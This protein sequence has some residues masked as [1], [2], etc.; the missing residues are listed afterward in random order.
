MA[1]EELLAFGRPSLLPLIGQT[2]IEQ[3]EVIIPQVVATLKT[4]VEDHNLQ[5]RLLA[6]LLAL[7]DDE[8]IVTMIEKLSDSDELFSDT[9]FLRRVRDRA[10]QEGLAEGR[11]QARA[12]A[13]RLA[14]RNTILEILALRFD[15]PAL[16]YRK[17]EKTLSGV[18]TDDALE[19]LFVIAIQA[20]TLAEFETALQQE[21]SAAGLRA[22]NHHT[23]EQGD[24]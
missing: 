20:Q 10:R 23:G 15:P 18:N 22:G 3:P 6:S 13:A 16:I 14:R 11:A 2:R 8:E 17:I 7:T 1:A 21:V 9:P 4:D 19:R 24:M 5:T 12:E